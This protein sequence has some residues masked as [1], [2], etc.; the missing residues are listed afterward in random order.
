MRSSA[1]SVVI[2]RPL[3]VLLVERLGA[4]IRAIDAGAAALLWTCERPGATSANSGDHHVSIPP[5]DLRR[6]ADGA[7]F[8]GVDVRLA[9]MLPPMAQKVVFV[10]GGNGPFHHVST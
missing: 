1:G 3:T 4:T 8:P 6:F 10:S 9:V 2:E 7:H 5:C